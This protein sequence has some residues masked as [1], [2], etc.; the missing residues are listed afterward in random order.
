MEKQ[1]FILHADRP[2]P[3]GDLGSPPEQQHGAGVDPSTRHWSVLVFGVWQDRF[4]VT[5]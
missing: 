4:K 5:T 3:S 2:P 1:L